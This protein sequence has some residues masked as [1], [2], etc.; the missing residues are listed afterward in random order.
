MVSEEKT[1]S[2]TEQAVAQ[3]G[4]Y[5]VIRNRL[6]KH[7]SSLESQ[8][9]QVN[10]SRQAEFGSTEM[11]LLS[12]LRLRTEN[13]CE[14]RDLVLVSDY[15]MF[16]Y[17]AFLGLRNETKVEDVFGLFKLVQNEGE[18]DVEEVSFKGTFLADQQF[19]G[20]F[21]EL[22]SYYKDTALSQLVVKDNKLLAAFQIGE[23][24]SDIRVFRWNISADGKTIEYI[25]NRGERDIALPPKYDFEWQ[26]CPR[27]NV[28]EGRYP[29]INILDTLFV[30]TLRGDLTVKVENNTESGMGIFSESVDDENQSLDDAEFYY[31]DLNSL[32]LIKVRPYM[33]EQWRYLVYNRNNQSIVRIDAIDDSCVQLPEDHGIIFPGGYYLTTGEY[34]QFEDSLDGLQYK[35]QL[36]SPNGEDVL[37][38][39]FHPSKNIVALYAYNL[40]NKSLQNPLLGHGFGFFDDGRLV[41]FYAQEEATRIHPV[42]IWQTPYFSDTYASEQPVKQTFFGKIGNAELVRGISELYSISRMVN[43]QD[44]S[45]SHYNELSKVCHKIFDNYYWLDSE[46]LGGIGTILHEI[47]AT[48][49]L[50]L[51]EYEK[52]ES[53]RAQSSQQLQQAESAQSDI[54][55]HLQAD[56]WHSPEEYVDALEKIRRHRGHLL[57][58][59][60]LRYMDVERIN[61]LETDITEHEERINQLTVE[62]LADD[63][64]LNSYDEKIEHIASNYESCR[65]TIEIQEH[66]DSLAQMAGGLDLLSELMAT[67]KVPDATIQTKIIEAVSEVYGKLNQQK[68]Q[69]E[70]QR[71]S[72]GAAEAAAQFGAQFKLLNQSI[73]NALGLSTTPDKCDEQLSRLL[74]QLEELEGQFSEHDEFLADILGKRDEIFETFETHKQQLTDARQRKCQTLFDAAQR[75]MQSITR[76]TQKFTEQDQLNTFFASDGLISKLRELADSLREYDDSV[77]ADDV[78]ARIKA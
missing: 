7:G 40:I 17:N 37:F 59:R 72:F 13:N 21:R 20:D 10:Q 73:H 2:L 64:A 67:L 68:A 62:F 45:A 6:S 58:I 35:R 23:R 8:T 18:Y 76:R 56:S 75:I 19:L 24:L 55:A 4:A 22:Y 31:A 60:D 33:E 25:D 26:R 3:G 52:V 27:H 65:T 70:H 49:E 16:G 32:I 71:K 78:D 15:V 28:I 36:R 51:D 66:L 38:I 11:A 74:V 57:T 9:G 54:V 42:Q 77:K 39:F 30:D 34:K 53:I 50:V 5:E 63:D 14:A 12:R 61:E 69:V 44:V 41:I 47:A 1:P 29:H 43:S 48:S 46:E